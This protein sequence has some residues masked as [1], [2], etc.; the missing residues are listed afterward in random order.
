MGLPHGGKADVYSW[1]LLAWSVVAV[2]E[3]FEGVGRSVFYDRVVVRAVP[4]LFFL[5]A[6]TGPALAKCGAPL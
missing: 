4:V 6:F 5:S 1:A 2:R 3:P